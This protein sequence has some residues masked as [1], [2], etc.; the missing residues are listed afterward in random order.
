MEDALSRPFASLE[1]LE[2][3]ISS[4]VK[5]S[6]AH[7]DS[8]GSLAR[9]V[10][11]N[12]TITEKSGAPVVDRCVFDTIAINSELEAMKEGLCRFAEPQR[13]RKVCRFQ[14][15]VSHQTG[16]QS[17]ESQVYHSLTYDSLR[18]L[19]SALQPI[20]E[21][22]DSAGASGTVREKLMDMYPGAAEDDYLSRAYIDLAEEEQR[23]VLLGTP[24]SDLSRLCD[25]LRYQLES[26]AYLF[27]R[28]SLEL[29]LSW[30]AEVDA[31]LDKLQA[32]YKD[33]AV[34]AR[35]LEASLIKHELRI[36]S[37]PQLP[38]HESLS[39]A[40]TSEAA[41]FKELPMLHQ[42]KQATGIQLTG[43]HYV[44]LRRRLRKWA[45]APAQQVPVSP[46][47]WQFLFSQAASSA[48]RQGADHDLLQRQMTP[49][50]LLD[51]PEVEAARQEQED[52]AR[53]EALKQ[54]QE[55][56]RRKE[57]HQDEV[58]SSSSRPQSIEAACLTPVTDPGRGKG[59]GRGRGRGRSRLHG[60]VSLGELVQADADDMQQL[61]DA[62]QAAKDRLTDLC[63]EITPIPAS[64]VDDLKGA[65]Q[66]AKDAGIS[67]EDAVVQSALQRRDETERIREQ[68][69][70]ELLRCYSARP[71]NDA[72]L[73]LLLKR[74]HETGMPQDS[75]EV[76]SATRLLREAVAAQSTLRDCLKLPFP[77][78]SDLRN[79]LQAA[80]DLQLT[81]PMLVE[82]TQK[83]REL[84]G[85]EASFAGEVKQ[86]WGS[87]AGARLVASSLSWRMM[88]TSH[89]LSTRPASSQ[90]ATKALVN[91]A[92][93]GDRK[94]VDAAIEAL[95]SLENSWS[96]A[97]AYL[98]AANACPSHI[99]VYRND[100]EDYVKDYMEEVGDSEDEV[101]LVPV[102]LLATARLCKPSET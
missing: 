22:V 96:H 56:E 37:S 65:L 24:A 66:A 3:R 25:F 48:P 23:A 52:R 11:N 93:C 40:F 81:D 57:M 45:A 26:E 28:K 50:F 74:A 34:D 99:D 13:Y 92:K 78:V 100:A 21:N 62:Q 4:V 75:A 72:E 64:L 90:A 70:T 6:L 85:E 27:A 35:S 16:G 43:A 15:S 39:R 63:A 83:L 89:G 8:V 98:A 59:R 80:N 31:E 84:E 38:I 41:L 29:K 18:G 94:S 60:S 53:A 67:D 76:E 77:A 47:T 20:K 17:Y 82:A 58:E 49:W 68:I 88:S 10:D 7:L 44:E 79:G 1:E 87:T 30:S 95:E 54:A 5:L 97:K 86:R 55:D 9:V 12:F 101:S 61:Q 51:P 71:L 19:I 46:W 14:A 73:H 2:V 42:L 91:L 102:I 69:R 33:L 32:E 36:A